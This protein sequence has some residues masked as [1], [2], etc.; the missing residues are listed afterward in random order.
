M[1]KD[2]KSDIDIKE[3]IISTISFS[4]KEL[5]IMCFEYLVEAKKLNKEEHIKDISLQNEAQVQYFINDDQLS[6]LL[7]AREGS[8]K[9]AFG[10]WSIWLK[11]R[12]TYHPEKI[13]VDTIINELGKEKAF[14]H[15]K[16][17]L[18]RP[19]I[20]IK[21]A[22][23]FPSE[24]SFDQ[25]MKFVV[26]WLE[27]LIKKCEKIGQKQIVA[28]IDRKDSGISNVDYQMIGQGGIISMLQDNYAE[29]LAFS[30]VI[31]IN[32][33]FRMV[34]KLV[35]PLMSE[36]TTSKLNL[37]SS[38]DELKNYFNTEDLL[39]EHG[40]TSDYKYKIPTDDDEI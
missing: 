6:R 36:R 9:K 4:N 19:C 12:Q 20:I 24:T 22:K 28:I 38:P 34:Y 14:I 7:V 21:T 3:N 8:V 35:K 2:Q 31:H 17:K 39:I 37:L 32:W 11:W 13:C 33:V 15:G 18:G 26:F 5:A 10:M 27:R 30:Y 40:G 1:E 23:H 29:R 16:D 25:T